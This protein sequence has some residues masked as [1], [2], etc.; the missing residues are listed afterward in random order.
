M[1]AGSTC[2]PTPNPPRAFDIGVKSGWH[3]KSLS[4]REQPDETPCIAVDAASYN[5]GSLGGKC[6]PYSEPDTTT[7]TQ[8]IDKAAIE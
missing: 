2:C 3:C 4:F 7:K 5:R 8:T 1:I 6:A